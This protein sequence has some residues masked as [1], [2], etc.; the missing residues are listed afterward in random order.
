MSTGMGSG[1]FFV[2]KNRGKVPEIGGNDECRRRL[3]GENNRR[4]TIQTVKWS[5]KSCNWSRIGGILVAV[6][7]HFEHCILVSLR[8]L[9]IDLTSRGVTASIDRQFIIRRVVA[10]LATLWC[11]VTR[12]SVWQQSCEQN[13]KIL[14]SVSPQMR[15][16]TTPPLKSGR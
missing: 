3:P 16:F 15:L 9:N 1:F 2:A 14:P 12:M 6:R 8:A 11:K 5:M 13:P 7:S 4:F 10:E